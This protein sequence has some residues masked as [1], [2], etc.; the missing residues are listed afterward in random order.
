[1]KLQTL[2]WFLKNGW[3]LSDG[4]TEIIEPNL[5]C[6]IEISLLDKELDFEA[7]P[8]STKFD[9]EYDDVYY[10]IEWFQDETIGKEMDYTRVQEEPVIIMDEEKVLDE[11]EKELINATEVTRVEIIDKNGRAYSK[12]LKDSDQIEYQ[13]QDDGKTLKIFIKD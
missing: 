8:N 6:Y 9:Y 12:W 4:E 2:D 3:E 7:L 13:V 1:M 10:K 11:V 5:R